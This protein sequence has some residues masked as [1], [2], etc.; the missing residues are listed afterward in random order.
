[1]TQSMQPVLRRSSQLLKGR[2]QA[3]LLH[4]TAWCVHALRVGLLE[5]IKIHGVFY[6]R[7]SPGE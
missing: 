6:L 5:E 4:L 7:L 2:A 3:R 1:M